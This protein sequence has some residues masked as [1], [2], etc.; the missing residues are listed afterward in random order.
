MLRAR[1]GHLEDDFIPEGVMDLFN[2][3]RVVMELTRNCTNQCAHCIN[4]S[5]PGHE[6]PELSMQQIVM[7]LNDAASND[8]DTAEFYGGEPF[9]RER[10]LFASIRE[11]LRR[12]MIVHIDTNG[13]WGRSPEKIKRVFDQLQILL[14]E[15]SNP[16]SRIHLNMSMSKWHQKEI[17][18]DS[19]INIIK[20][21]LER[22]SDRIHIAL[23]THTTGE[24]N[25]FFQ[26]FAQ[27]LEDETP[28]EN[29]LMGRLVEQGR[30]ICFGNE[31]ITMPR[32][33]TGEE[34]MALLVKN[35][36]LD[37]ETAKKFSGKDTVGLLNTL[38]QNRLA[39]PELTDD[40]KAIR[41]YKLIKHSLSFSDLGLALLGRAESLLDDPK[42]REEIVQ[43]RR[44]TSEDFDPIQTVLANGRLILGAD[45]HYYAQ[46]GQ[47]AEGVSPLCENTGCVVGTLTALMREDVVFRLLTTRDT[48]SVVKAIR[49]FPDR[50]SSKKIS[51]L[52]GLGLKYE[53][54]M[55]A[56]KDDTLAAIVLV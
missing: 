29:F 28:Y 25:S 38:A 6:G 27:K 50:E 8:I 30:D 48:R 40:R 52:L 9:T 32:E 21:W 47:L 16:T 44:E 33:I 7:A 18:I 55:T 54:I 22:A 41:V 12:N 39:F 4:E 23:T 53:A 1:P 34:A 3:D 36:I 5:R 26:A 24:D 43:T 56:I 15:Y 51:R 2:P 11:A 13:F 35:G 45:N 19:V 20:E 10:L 37:E 46:P 17:P 49:E 14:K 31:H 42:E